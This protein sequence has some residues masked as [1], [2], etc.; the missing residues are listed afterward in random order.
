MGLL[1]DTSVLV[2][3]ERGRLDLGGLLA[4]GGE[5]AAL[6]AITAAELLHGVHRL[7]GAKR[8]RAAVFVEG[9]LALLPV[10]PFDVAAA[11][12]HAALSADLRTRGRAVGPHDLLIAATAIAVDYAVATRDVRS[13]PRIDGLE[14]VAL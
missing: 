5:E 2:D 4:R 12:V 13:Y 3:A 1:I 8:A 14:V 6:S 11:R 7:T 10:L 9:L